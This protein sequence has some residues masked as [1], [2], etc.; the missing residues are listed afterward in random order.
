[1][2]GLGFPVPPPVLR[3]K[4][5]TVLEPLNRFITLVEEKKGAGHIHLVIPQFIPKKWWHNLM[6][7]QTALQLRIWFLRHKDVVITTVPYHLKK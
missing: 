5:R 3:S 6:H 1:M 4:Y 2:E 7:N